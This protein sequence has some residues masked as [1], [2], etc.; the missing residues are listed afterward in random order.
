MPD[1]Y[2][3]GSSAEQTD[4]LPAVSV[5]TQEP[6]TEAPAPPQKRFNKR[7]AAIIG[8]SVFGGLLLLWGADLLISSGSVPRGVT[9]AGVDVGG[10]S[11]DSAEKELRAK[12][13]PRLS[14]PVQVKAGDVTDQLAP[15]VSGL[16]LDWPGTLDQAGDQPL[17]PFTRIA[18]FFTSREVGV[19]THADDA[20]LKQ[21]MEQ[22][23]AKTDRDPIEGTIRFD[24]AEPVLVEAKQGQKLDVP[25]ATDA[26]LAHW[27]AGQA[28]D[29]PVALTPV[30][31]NPDALKAAFEQIAKPAVA[32]PLIIKGEGKDAKLEPAQIAAALS[33]EPITL[34]PK[35]DQEKVVEA[36]G[37]QLKSTEKE[38]K[39]AS[40]V[41]EGGKPAVEPSVDGRGVDWEVSLKPMVDVLK[42][43]DK[44][45]LKATYKDTPAKVTTE[46]ANQLGV[47][48]VIGEFTTGGFAADS[49]VNI[50]VVA[51]KV[52]G[53][54]VKP[55]E[56]FSL[57]GFTGP[58]GTKQGYVEA[59]VISDGAPGREVGG[60]ISQ[61]ATTLYNA[62]YFAGMKDAGHK[63]HSYY[64]SRYPAAR[65]ATVF[66]NHDGS[67]VIDLKFTN[68]SQTGVAIQTIWTPSSLTVKLW[69]TARYKVESIAGARTNQTEPQPKA[70][71]AE[72]CHAS[73]GAPGFTTTDTRVLRDAAT[74]REV[75]RSTRT[76]KYNPQPKITC[77]E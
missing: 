25:A 34:A 59:G 57:N 77:G 13:E 73:N 19:V 27:A 67:S 69:G 23:R 37:P 47:K 24:E 48:E 18:S 39:E 66:Q 7:K 40:I 50:H 74:G 26:V 36:A 12:I 4:I 3:P 75:S 16:T 44:R 51:N 52:D 10:M 14:S 76:V 6:P 11:R 41:F 2:W 35:I 9:V 20:K 32:A 68:D 5:L 46:Q 33:F 65:E 70:G 61:F 31:T 55:G 54:I 29:L 49:G 63:E 21:A 17:N 43:A 45:E 64:I 15:K 60:G 28:L 38:G 72:N 30:Q 42:L 56:T 53:A 58:R 22:L 1:S 71:P 8:G 62:A